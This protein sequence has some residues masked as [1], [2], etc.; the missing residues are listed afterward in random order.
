MSHFPTTLANNAVID[1][2]EYEEDEQPL[3]Y[4][5]EKET[6]VTS[7]SLLEFVMATVVLMGLVELKVTFAYKETIDLGSI[8]SYGI[9]LH[10]QII[11]NGIARNITGIAIG[12][13]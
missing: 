2:K 6:V 11:E 12:W 1:I 5:S 7:I 8:G 10:S 9:S 3:N 13:Y 4:N